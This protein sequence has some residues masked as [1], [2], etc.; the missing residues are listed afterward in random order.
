MLELSQVVTL[1]C[2]LVAVAVI[3]SALEWLQQVPHFTPQGIFNWSII[4]TLTPQRTPAVVREW[5]DWLSTAPGVRVGF[6]LEVVFGLLLFFT[7]GLPVRTIPLIVLAVL[8][9][10]RQARIP[11]GRDGADQM[12]VLII[13][14]LALGTA[15]GSEYA[16]TLALLFIAGQACLSYFIS[17]VAKLFGKPWWN[18]A[19]AEI[20]ATRNYGHPT[21]A[22]LFAGRPWFTRLVTAGVVLGEMLFW[23]VLFLPSPWVAVI[24]ALGLLFH[25]LNA[26]FMG[27]NTFFWAFAASY[28]AIYYISQLDLM[29][30]VLAPAG[31]F[32]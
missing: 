20:M 12:I 10:A 9:V 7:A 8:L 32:S 28:P 19:L 30:Q 18:V 31:I 26:V 11:F 23:T 25:A 1:V 6:A 3:I 5:T 2:L 16:I 13:V 29:A 17:G 22:A 21:A 15:I 24:L 27:L 4:A 14:P